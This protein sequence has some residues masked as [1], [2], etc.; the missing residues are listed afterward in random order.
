M[1]CSITL[2]QAPTKR[3]LRHFKSLG[4]ISLRSSSSSN[5]SDSSNSSN[6]SEEIK[7]ATV[8]ATA[9]PEHQVRVIDLPAPPHHIAVDPATESAPAQKTPAHRRRPFSYIN[10][11]CLTRINGLRALEQRLGAATI[12]NHKD[13]RSI[14][15][16]QRRLRNILRRERELHFLECRNVPVLPTP[17]NTDSAGWDESEVE[18]GATTPATTPVSFK[19][20]ANEAPTAV[21]TWLEYR[22]APSPD[23]PFFSPPTLKRAPALR[24]KHPRS[25][26]R[27]SRWESRWVM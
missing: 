5:S 21:S 4:H 22:Q 12:F 15:P 13:G 16:S 20:K 1:H 14:L 8:L 27:D 11:T 2:L 9:K 3:L 18:T 26:L 24:R 17:T 25:P 23:G 10:T 6:D 7:T 19:F